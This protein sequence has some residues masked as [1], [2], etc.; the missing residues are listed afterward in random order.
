MYYDKTVLSEEDVAT[1]DG[2]IEKANAAGKAFFFPMSDPWYNAGFFFTA[3]CTIEYKNGVQTATFN[4][5]EGLAAVK[6]MCHI[7][8]KVGQGYEAPQV[9]M[10]T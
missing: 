5:D 10:L 2:I 9:R 1:F 4:T 3:G 8:E 7:A 6:A